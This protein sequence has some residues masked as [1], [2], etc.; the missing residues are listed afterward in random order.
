MT[1]LAFTLG[2]E[3][4]LDLYDALLNHQ[5]NRVESIIQ[6][7]PE[8][9]DKP[10]QQIY[11]QGRGDFLYS[12][13]DMTP[14]LFSIHY[15]LDPMVSLL[16]RLGADPDRDN[17]LGLLPLHEAARMG[18]SE[19]LKKLLDAGALR[20]AG[21]E[22]KHTALTRAL[23]ACRFETADL[24][25]E[26]GARL[27]VDSPVSDDLSRDIYSRKIAMRDSL[28]LRDPGLPGYDL[29]VAARDGDYFKMQML[30]AQ[31]V[32]PDSRDSEGIT[33]L[34]MAAANGRLYE[35]RLLL[36]S[37]AEVNAA[38]TGGLRA[39]SLAAAMGDL[40]MLSMLHAY[41]A[42][43]DRGETLDESAL[44]FALVYREKAA[45]EWLLQKN[46]KVNRRDSGGRTAIMIASWLGDRWSVEELLTHGAEP[47]IGD[48]DGNSAIFYAIEVYNRIGSIDY[49]MLIERLIDA[50]VNPRRYADMT[51]DPQLHALLEARWD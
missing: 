25:V 33:P 18:N 29:L 37:G 2:A 26:R 24:L 20:E 35:A 47:S 48:Y 4:E 46:I 1:L 8:L 9:L 11:R 41:G 16:L 42:D 5:T 39:L 34:M 49:Y 19:A 27:Y 51:R 6:G 7:F 40:K 17:G 43:L 3:T 12:S 21:G 30:L 31:G 10:S 45:L 14:L 38:S 28:I 23:E 32:D 44:Y 13:Q 22:D 15:R 50:G 36:D